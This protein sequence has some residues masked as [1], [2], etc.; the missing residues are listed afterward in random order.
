MARCECRNISS[1]FFSRKRFL[2]CWKQWSEPF[3]ATYR[4]VQTLVQT[5]ECRFCGKIQVKAL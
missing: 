3:Q 1:A 5:R 2:H 4:G